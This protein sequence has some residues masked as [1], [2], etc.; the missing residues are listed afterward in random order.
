[1]ERLV[2]NEPLYAGEQVTA[3]RFGSVQQ[4]GIQS[5]LKGTLRAFQ[6]SGDQNQLLAGTVKDGDHVDLVATLR[7]ATRPTK[8]AV[9]RV[10]LRDLEVL[11]AP[12]FPEISGKVSN[13]SAGTANI[14]LAVRDTAVPKLLL[15]TSG[16]SQNDWSLQLR[17]VVD[18]ADSPPTLESTTP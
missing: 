1:M 2:L 8:P 16:G 5:K 18:P 12:A 11:R 10:V 15:T 9:S 4:E 7:T 3:R 6:L 13:T 17:P 14:Q